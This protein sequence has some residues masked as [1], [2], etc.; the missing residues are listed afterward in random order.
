MKRLFSIITLAL[1]TICPVRAEI[2][3][4]DACITYS[5]FIMQADSLFFRGQYAESSALFEKGFSTE[6]LHQRLS[7]L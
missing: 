2:V 5:R 4:D 7:S 3:D 1:L 6:R